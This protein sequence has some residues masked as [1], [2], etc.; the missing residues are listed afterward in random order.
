MGSTI[1]TRVSD[2]LAKDIEF[3]TDLE[4]LDKSTMTRKLLSDAVEEKLIKHA[5]E[6][7]KNSEVTL[8]GAASIA[9]VPLRKIM[10][11]V[12]DQKIPMQYSLKNLHEDFQAVVEK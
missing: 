4:K 2:E 5:I 8:W 6:K 10:K 1:T 12:R 11:E 7:Y 9:R 3:F